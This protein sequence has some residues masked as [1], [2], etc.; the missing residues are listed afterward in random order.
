MRRGIMITA[1]AIGVAGAVAAGLAWSANN[2]GSPFGCRG[3]DPELTR[4]VH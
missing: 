3:A 1:V 4:L 2:C